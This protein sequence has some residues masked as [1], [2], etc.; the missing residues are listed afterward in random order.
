[1]KTFYIAL[2][3]AVSAGMAAYLSPSQPY[4]IAVT[5]PALVVLTIHY[6]TYVRK[7]LRQF[8]RLQDTEFLMR[9][10]CPVCYSMEDLTST[11]TSI[12]CE[13]CGTIFVVNLD[14]GLVDRRTPLNP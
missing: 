3:S 11:D 2:V 13:G 8:Q 7:S 5:V 6:F 14:D 9:S 12:A 10:R 1:M 4:W